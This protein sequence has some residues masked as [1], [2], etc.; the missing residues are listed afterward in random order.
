MPPSTP[1]RMALPNWVPTWLATD[2]ATCLATTSVT[3]AR[4]DGRPPRGPGVPPPK[5]LSRMPPRPPAS[6]AAG[7]RCLG[8]RLR[9]RL[10]P[11]RTGGGAGRAAIALRRA[12]AGALLQHLI[13]GL[14]IDRRVVLAAQ[15]AAADDR[16]PLLRRDRA[17]A[18]RRRPDQRALH[19]RGHALVL[20]H[21]DQRLADAQLG[22]RLV[23]VEAPGWAGRS[24]PRPSPP[25]ARA[26]VIGAQRVLHA[27]AE[28]GQHA[29]REC[30][31]GS[32]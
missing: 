4:P 20:E 6:P 22:D 28:L 32:G 9:G 18:R 11:P 27:V 25:S 26:G 7:G 15:R 2:R 29:S 12:L 5:M 23:G 14:R 8:R 17:D 16:R 30:R 10:A 19:H 3:L 13:G 31:A 21:R 24:R 1:R